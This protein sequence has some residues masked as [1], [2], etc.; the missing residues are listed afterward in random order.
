MSQTCYYEILGVSRNATEG[1]I[2][3]AYRQM[4]LKY[5]P[6]RN[7]GDKEAE[8]KFKD[9]AEAYEVL[10][11]PEKREL[12]D[13][14]GHSG[15]NNMGGGHPF[16]SAEDIFSHFSDIFGDIFG[17]S[18]GG[19][20]GRQNRPQQGASLRYNQ[21]LSFRQAAK[22]DSIKISIPRKENCCECGGSGAKP[23]TS[24]EVCSQCGGVG[25]IV[26]SQGFFQ[27]A[28]PCPHCRGKGQIIAQ[29]CP[30]CT[31]EGQVEQVRELSV[32]VPAG[33]DSGARLRLRGE[34]EA[35]INGGPSGDLY[36]DLYV[37]EDDIFG[38]DGQDLL[39]SRDVSFPDAALGVNISIP[40]LD[41]DAELEIP[42][43]TQSGTVLRLAGRGLP[44]PNSQRRG[45]L[46]VQITVHTPT[47]LSKRQIELLREFQELEQNKPAQ[48]FKKFIKEAGKAMGI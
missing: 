26:R 47:S 44:Y 28:V 14:Y 24:P 11:D 19:G 20:A 6:D 45:D 16:A 34:G 48:K 15:L 33:V 8:Q 38:R 40:T 13:R 31:G 39:L 9:C 27:L 21:K 5:H 22:G 25:Q 10:R 41:E 12:Y 42:K 7:P 30:A 4:A 17:F 32:K 2:K 3:K 35:G 37:E 43:G 23:G 18:M 1:E 29:R 36:V 46:L